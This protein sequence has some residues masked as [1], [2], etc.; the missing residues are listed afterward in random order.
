VG[1]RR[2]LEGPFLPPWPGVASMERERERDSER[3]RMREIEGWARCGL[4]A[5]GGLEA[6]PQ[7]HELCSGAPAP[8][9]LGP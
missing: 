7:K 1:H 5:G 8:G 4:L 9:R 2:E 3:E 6:R